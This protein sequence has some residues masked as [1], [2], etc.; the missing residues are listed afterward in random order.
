MSLV[1]ALRDYIDF[2]NSS[3]D[4]VSANTGIN[5]LLVPT[6]LYFIGSFKHVAVYLLSF[7][8]LRDLV[9]LPLLVPR[10]SLSILKGD[11]YPL[12]NPVLNFFT[13][14]EEPAY[15][16]NR[17]LIGFLNSSIRFPAGD[18][19]SRY[20]WKEIACTRHSCRGCCRKWHCARAMV[21][22]YLCDPWATILS[23]TLALFRTIQLFARP[24]STD[25]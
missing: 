15:N 5:Q 4:S 13:F 19:C 16:E 3:F 24:S 8:W 23:F 12:E 10:L 22:P 25:W 18:C 9:Q 11:C 17:L 20:G 14:L 21:V 1:S 6:L 2:I 7:Q